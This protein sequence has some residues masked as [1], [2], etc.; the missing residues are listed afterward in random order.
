MAP[1]TLFVSNFP[2]ATTESELRLTVEA[3][4]SVNGI[5]IITDRETGRSRGFAFIE[6]PNDSAADAAIEALNDSMLSGRRVVVSRAKG[7]AAASA[8]AKAP[9][10][11]AAPA[12]TAPFKH[13]IVIDWRED[14]GRYAA[15]VPELGVVV[16]AETIQDA[17]RQVQALT[18][19]S[20]SAAG[21]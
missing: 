11:A 5:R 9:N 10:A 12:P 20:V 2:F 17:V 14:E 8:G 7:R 18:Q 16:R 13:R 4:S 21:G 15:E 19:R 1:C 6:V 3:H